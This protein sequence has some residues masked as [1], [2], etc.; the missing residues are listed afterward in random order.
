VLGDGWV[1]VVPGLACPGA[2]HDRHMLGRTQE[3]LANAFHD[4]WTWC[5]RSA[6]HD[7]C[8]SPLLGLLGY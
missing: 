6:R 8:G 7:V 1:R 5:F 2:I 4:G 3:S